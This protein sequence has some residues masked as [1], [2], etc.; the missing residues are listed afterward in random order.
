VACCSFDIIHHVIV[1]IREDGHEDL[2]RAVPQRRSRYMWYFQCRL[3]PELQF[4]AYDWA[5]LEF[6]YRGSLLGAKSPGAAVWSL[7]RVHDRLKRSLA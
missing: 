1:L 5:F 4:A 7:H 6:F 2:I 3:I